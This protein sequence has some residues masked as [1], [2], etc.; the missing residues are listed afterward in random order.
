MKKKLIH[1]C[2]AT[3]YL[4]QSVR[5]Q[6]ICDKYRNSKKEKHYLKMA[7]IM[8]LYISA[9]LQDYGSLDV[10]QELRNAEELSTNQ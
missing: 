2:N 6:P 10:I 4:S 1:F 7:G 5:K 8:E 3:L 9:S